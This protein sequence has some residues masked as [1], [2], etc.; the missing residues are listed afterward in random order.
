RALRPDLAGALTSFTDNDS[1]KAIFG[2]NGIVPA[3]LG[4][5]A[6]NL[7]LQNTTTPVSF[8]GLDATFL[9]EEEL[10]WQTALEFLQSKDVYALALLSQ[11]PVVHQDGSVHVTAMSDPKV[12]RE[13]VCFISRKLNTIAVVVP[14]SG[15]GAN[16]GATLA[17]AGYRTLRD[18]NGGF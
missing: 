4:A 10:S 8:T 9:T 13:R 7:A 15:L 6:I 3:N 11:N 5:Y 12:G 14:T 1:L 16:A 2:T 17:G 18:P